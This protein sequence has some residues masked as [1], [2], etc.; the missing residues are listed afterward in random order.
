MGRL[1]SS[2]AFWRSERESHPTEADEAWRR[3]STRVISSGIDKIKGN[4]N[5]SDA[6]D[7]P[8]VTDDSELSAVTE[9]PYNLSL[10]VGGIFII[11]ATSFLGM[12]LSLVFDALKKREHFGVGTPAEKALN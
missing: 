12:G 5:M 10:Q 3:R 8:S 2:C 1:F 7:A 11:I 4:G 6:G 9:D